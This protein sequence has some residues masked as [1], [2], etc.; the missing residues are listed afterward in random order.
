M[1]EKKKILAI[2]P[3]RGGSKGLPGKNIRQLLGKP[4]IAWTIE[5]AKQSKYIDE[6]FVSTDSPEIAE[7]SDIFGVTVPILRPDK[8]AEDGSKSIDVIEHVV[9]YFDK[10]NMFFD[11]VVL[12]EPTSPLRESQDIDNAVLSLINNKAAESIVGVCKSE[13]AHPSFSVT[14]DTGFIKPYEKCNNTLRRQDIKDIY[15]FEGSLYLS[16][17]A[18]LKQRRTFYHEKT[19]PYIVPKWKSYEVDD[20]VDWIIIEALLTARINKKISLV[21]INLC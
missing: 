19:L 4:L 11:L 1:I 8:L 14:I 5:Q 16:Y 6:I 21:S 17:T 2:I 13:S 18:S 10:N 7:V 3:A 20:L 12:L 9:E 15:F